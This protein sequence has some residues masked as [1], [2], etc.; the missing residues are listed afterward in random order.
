MR[1][2]NEWLGLGDHQ[3]TRS[4][5]FFRCTGF[6]KS[7]EKDEPKKG[8]GGA[9]CRRIA[10]NCNNPDPGYLSMVLSM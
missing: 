1:S 7:K 8:H 4:R 2:A 9:I 3:N 5:D 10:R 6:V